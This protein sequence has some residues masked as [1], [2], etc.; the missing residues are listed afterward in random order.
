MK[1][2]KQKIFLISISVIIGFLLLFIMNFFSITNLLATQD[3]ENKSKNIESNAN[4]L[5]TWLTTR[6]SELEA[7]AASPT[8]KTMN[9]SKIKP[10]LASEQ[11]RL[12]SIY[13]KFL[14]A[15]TSGDYYNTATDTKGNIA[16]RDYFPLVMSGK[17]IISNP[18]ISKSNGLK[19]IV[20]A[21]PIKDDS[22][23][24]IGLLGTTIPLDSFKNFVN[25]INKDSKARI[26][27]VDSKGTVISHPDDN[28]VMNLNLIE[29]GDNAKLVTQSMTDATKEVIAG[30]NGNTEYNFEGKNKRLFYYPVKSANWGAM[31]YVEKISAVQLFFEY[32][33]NQFFLSIVILGLIT[34]AMFWLSRKIMTPI[35]EITSKFEVVSKG[36]LTV[37]LDVKSEDELGKLSAHLNNFLENL[38]DVIKGIMTSSRNVFDKSL[39]ISDDV[40]ATANSINQVTET[41]NQLA[42]ASGEQTGHVANILNDIEGVNSNVKSIHSEIQV[43]SDEAKENIIKAE[44]VKDNVNNVIGNISKVKNISSDVS[45]VIS[46]L[47]ELSSQ[48]E[49]IVDL[50]KTIAGQTNLLA[51]NAAIEAARAGEHGKGFAVVADEVKKLATQSAEATDEITEIVRKIHEKT[52]QAVKVAEL[53]NTEVEKS[54]ITV[55]EVGEF[56]NDILDENKAREHKLHDMFEKIND[57]MGCSDNVVSM[58]ENVSSLVEESAASTEEISASAQ[59]QNQNIDKINIVTKEFSRIAGEMNDLLTRFKTR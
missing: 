5:D 31:L 28:Y 4:Y 39:V 21:A 38:N 17:T 1:T 50:I 34:G 44:K 26:F 23:K 42:I 8:L 9:W 48:I 56:I 40:Q 6:T 59:E 36:D 58:A 27:V 7:I 57:L 51:L 35:S 18:V 45:G 37:R 46:Q 24:V 53:G 30:K 41:I 29:P 55:K 47:S 3:F 14:V 20:V 43:I 12:G 49:V 15:D 25:Q 32:F 10:Y 11:K 33:T 16:S 52:E 54:V 2:L 19:Q 22:N 13:E